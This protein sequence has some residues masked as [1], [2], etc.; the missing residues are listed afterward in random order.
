[1]FTLLALECDGADLII[2]TVQY[3]PL[4]ASGKY[5]SYS[6]KTRSSDIDGAKKSDVDKVYL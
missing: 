6:D 2:L 4:L 1:M 3:R 5:T